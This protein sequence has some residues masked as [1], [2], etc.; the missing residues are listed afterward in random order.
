M[1]QRAF[2][3]LLA[4]T[5]MVA[6][7][8][9]ATITLD[10]QL[11]KVAKTYEVFATVDGPSKG[12]ASFSIDILGAGGAAVTSSLLQVPRPFDADLGEFIG[13]TLLRSNG[14]T[15]GTNRTGVRASQDTTAS[16]P[17][18][19]IF[20]VGVATPYL[21]VKLASGSYTGALGTL[22]AKVTTGNFFN[23]FPQDYTL[24]SNTVAATSVI[25][26]VASVPEPAT[27][28]LMAMGVAMVGAVRLGRR[29]RQGALGANS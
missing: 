22:T 2:L 25:P 10:L 29:R 7:S 1:I 26:A 15:S 16:D 27:M 9:A 28:A 23:L 13:F 14:A 4:L 5:A 8:Q 20:D 3:V 12:L 17:A 18:F 6:T 11:N 19:L 24:G 21:P